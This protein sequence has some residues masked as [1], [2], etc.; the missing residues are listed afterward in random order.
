MTA[1]LINVNLCLLG[2]PE[3]SPERMLGMGHLFGE[4]HSIIIDAKSMV[5][6]GRYMNVRRSLYIQ[7]CKF[8]GSRT[9]V[10]KGR[11]HHAFEAGF[12]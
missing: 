1:T 9:A 6:L 3:K 12:V 2:E 10:L 11:M 7:Y 5:N 4:E 8:L